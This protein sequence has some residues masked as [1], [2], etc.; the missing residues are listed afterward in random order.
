MYSPGK[1]KKRSCFLLAFRE[2]VSFCFPPNLE[3]EKVEEEPPEILK[4]Q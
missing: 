1:K 2:L 4:I 3:F